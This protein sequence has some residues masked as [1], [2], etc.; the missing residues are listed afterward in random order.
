MRKILTVLL[1]TFGVHVGAQENKPLKAVPIDEFPNEYLDT[2]TVEKKIEINDYTMIGVHYGIGLSQVMF[3]P[4][5]KQNMMFVPVNFGISFTKYGRMFG[6]MPF[7]GIEAGLLYTKEGYQFEKN[8]KDGI[9]TIG[10]VEGA[11]KAIMEVVEAPVLMVG[12]YDMLNFKLM[13]KLGC[14][15]GY[16]L[17]VERFPGETGYVKPEIE[18]AFLDTD[19]RIDYGIKGGLGFGLVFEPLE[20]HIQALYKH[21]LSSLYNPNYYS[22]YYYRFAFPSNISITAGLHFHL[23]KRTGKTKADIKKAAK[24]IVYGE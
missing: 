24:G 15:A 23:S 9:V 22:D 21:S 10:Q 1:I 12:H 19:R 6:Y 18:K 14:Y 16:R 3:N 2:L 4:T 11:E 13:L 20:I 7:F 5:Q 8:E 17:S